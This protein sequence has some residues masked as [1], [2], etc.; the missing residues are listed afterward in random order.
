MR[1]N[2]SRPPVVLLNN[3]HAAM[4]VELTTL[5][6]YL[7]A[8]W[9]LKSQ[10]EGGSYFGS[11]AARIIMSVITE[12]MLHM[13]LVANVINAIGGTFTLNKEHF[14]PKYPSPILRHNTGSCG[15]EVGLLRFSNAALETFLNIEKPSSDQTCDPGDNKERGWNTIGEFY[16]AIEKQLTGDLNYSH[17]NQLELYNNLGLGQL[18]QVTSQKTALDALELIV[19][20]GE[21]FEEKKPDGTE[22][23]NQADGD[24]EL[25]HYQKFLNVQQ[26]LTQGDINPL[27]DV[28]QVIDN[29]FDESYTPDQKRANLAFNSTYSKLLDVLQ[30]AF[31]NGDSSIFGQPTGLMLQLTQQAAVLRQSGFVTGT[32]HL[33]GPTF[34]Y[35]PVKQRI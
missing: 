34:E 7:Y 1:N 18:I 27:T 35:I 26:W 4:A 13:G 6:T 24:N 19:D 22:G 8:F 21:G 10:E 12:E 33:A 11:L 14:I 32:Q 15:Y 20:Q 16:K 17:G 5:P 29:P 3:L 30:S 9:S 31:V 28:H 25:S 23:V 2:I